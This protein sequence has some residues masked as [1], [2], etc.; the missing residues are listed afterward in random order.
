[1][2][3]HTVQREYFE[4]INF[5]RNNV[6]KDFADLMFMNWE[7]LLHACI[8]GF[9]FAVHAF[10]ASVRMRKRG[11]R[12]C[13]CV[14]VRLSVQTAT[15]AQ[16]SMK[17]KSEFLQASSHVF[18]DLQ[19]NASFELSLYLLG[20]PL[21]TFQNCAQKNLSMECCY[22]TQ[23]LALHQNAAARVRR[24]LKG[25]AEANNFRLGTFG[26]NPF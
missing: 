21:Q 8:C 23:Q 1:M 17:C 7:F 2:I 25:S 6:R 19:N 3:K 16:G 24:E 13:V 10:Y 5:R 18:L 12:Q 14:C 20:M 9:M 26:I 22:S 4:D 11:I 15:A